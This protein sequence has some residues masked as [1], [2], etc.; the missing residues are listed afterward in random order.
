ME[1]ADLFLCLLPFLLLGAAPLELRS[2]LLFLPS[3]LAAPIR[4]GSRLRWIET[5][6]D[7]AP[8]APGTVSPPAPDGGAPPFLGLRERLP[9]PAVFLGLPDTPAAKK[10]FNVFK[11]CSI[12]SL[13]Y[14]ISFIVERWSKST[15]VNFDRSKLIEGRPIE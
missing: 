14:S 11:L 4:L 12:I 15:A 6:R 3:I 2:R 8:S 5:R 13:E 10:R 1:A 9:P 7:P